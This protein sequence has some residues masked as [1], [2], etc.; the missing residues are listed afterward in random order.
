LEQRK[1][2]YTN[3]GSP[4][5][6]IHKNSGEI[7]KLHIPG[8]FVGIMEHTTYGQEEIEICVGDRIFIFTDGL[9]E[10]KSSDDEL[11]GIDRLID[12]V[13]ENHKTNLP[14]L[15]Q[16]LIGDLRKFQGEMGQVDDLTLI[17]IEIVQFPT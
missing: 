6:I 8:M 17:I 14:K 5:V 3:A 9:S 2:F 15:K 10:T 11:Y 4:P 16:L 12:V 1:L 7:I 13:R